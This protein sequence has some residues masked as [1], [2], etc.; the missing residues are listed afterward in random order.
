MTVATRS[1]GTSGIEV[2]ELCF[3]TS[4]LASMARLYGYEVD[5]RRAIDTVLAVL[6]SPIR[7]IDTSN[8]YGEN[9]TAERRIGAAL[10]EYGGLPDDVV[11]ATK[12]DPDPVTG[13]FSGA[14]VRASLD[15]SLERLGVDRIP[16]LHL[17]DPERITFEQGTA[18][19]GPVAALVDLKRQG[20]VDHIGVAGGPVDLLGRYLDTGAFDVV[21]SHNRHTLLDRSADALFEAARA[22]GIGVLNAAPFGGGMLAKG[23]AVQP[24][25]AY[26]ERDG[27]IAAAASAMQDA[28]THHGV[29]L[30]A[31]ALQFSLRSE[32]VDSTVVGISTPE[33]VEQTLEYAAMEIPAELW[34]ELEALAPPADL[35]LH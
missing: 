15:E 28:C 12:V 20:V 13:D 31:A 25:Y 29:P 8:G 33:R 22:R 18:D 27:R 14:R 9:G 17:H 32:V 23:P 21:L 34:D 35:W 7:F 2:S 4:P 5:E 11:L 6:E 24:G 16:L 26:G 30:P 19:D 3:G 1:L 10:R